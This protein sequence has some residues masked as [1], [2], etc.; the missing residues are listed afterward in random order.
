MRNEEAKMKPLIE[1]RKNHR[2]DIS[3]EVVVLFKIQF[4]IHHITFYASF[5]SPFR[6]WFICALWGSLEYS[7]FE[8]G[9]SVKPFDCIWLAVLNALTMIGFTKMRWRLNII[10]SWWYSRDFFKEDGREY[11]DRLWIL[12]IMIDFV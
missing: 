2:V 6:M 11:R 5:F 4:L 3:T 8:F 1:E 9:Q 7:A 12:M 10:W